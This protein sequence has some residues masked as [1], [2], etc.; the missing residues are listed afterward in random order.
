M[1]C[2]WQC[3]FYCNRWDL[4]KRRE[5]WKWRSRGREKSPKIRS[6]FLRSG[7]NNTSLLGDFIQLLWETFPQ[8][9]HISP[10]LFPNCTFGFVLVFAYSCLLCLFFSFASLTSSLPCSGKLLRIRLLALMLLSPRGFGDILS[11]PFGLFQILMPYSLSDLFNYW[12]C[13]V[14]YCPLLQ[15]SPL[16][17]E[18]LD[19]SPFAKTTSVQTFIGHFFFL[20]VWVAHKFLLGWNILLLRMFTWS[21]TAFCSIYFVWKEQDQWGRNN[22]TTICGFTEMS[23]T[24]LS[25]GNMIFFFSSS[26]SFKLTS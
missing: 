14:W 8:T 10:A 13:N 25:K 7:D 17:S 12:T 2:N 9:K 3:R 5:E 19:I 15:I 11:S 1:K 21:A 18:F 26:V 20:P 24:F 6:E 23:W 4:N 22:F 16:A